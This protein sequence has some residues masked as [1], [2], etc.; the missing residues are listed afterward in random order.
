MWWGL[1]GIGFMGMVLSYVFFGLI[2][3]LIVTVI[4][5]LIRRAGNHYDHHHGYHHDHYNSEDKNNA[6]D[7]LKVRYAKGEITK[8]QYESMKKDLGF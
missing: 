5:R 8:E 3:A 7:I 6:L 2:I 1:N 4:I